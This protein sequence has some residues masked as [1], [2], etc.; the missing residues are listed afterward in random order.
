MAGGGRGDEDCWLSS[1]DEEEPMDGEEKKSS[2]EDDG[3]RACCGGGGHSSFAELELIMV[4]FESDSII[5]KPKKQ[6]EKEEFK[7][8]WRL[9]KESS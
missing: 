1:E 9:F 8:L 2:S 5:S 7:I 4:G 3:G 6:K